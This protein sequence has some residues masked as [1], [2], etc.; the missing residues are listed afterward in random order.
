M[1]ALATQYQ[2]LSFNF[3]A[4]EEACKI[5]GGEDEEVRCNVADTGSSISPHCLPPSIAAVHNYTV[6]VYS[7][8]VFQD[9]DQAIETHC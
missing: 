9:G 6:C 8:C 3:A 4:A 5:T 1:Q 7:S 2:Q